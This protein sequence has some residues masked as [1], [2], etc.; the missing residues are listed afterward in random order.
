MCYWVLTSNGDVVADTTV[1][2]VTREDMAN[3]K[4]KKQVK[5]FNEAIEVRLNDTN[6]QLPNMGPFTLEDEGYDLPSWDP[7]YGNNTPDDS[8]YGGMVED[9][10]LADAEEVDDPEVYDKLIGAKVVLDEF[11]NAGGNIATVKRRATDA[12]GKPLGNAH[13]KIALDTRE[14]EIELEDGTEDR[15][16]ANKIAANIYSHL[17]DEGRE[18]LA[19]GDIV[20]HRKNGHEISKKMGSQPWRVGTRSAR[21]PQGGGNFWSNGRMEPQLGWTSRT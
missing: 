19:F 12:S 20:D 21:R 3:P 15:I 17:D 16:M 2:H 9:T 8:E 18:I 14:Y 1:Q 10:P 6:F 7:A 11:S 13:S 5:A 4:I